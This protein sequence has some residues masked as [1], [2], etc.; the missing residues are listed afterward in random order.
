MRSWPLGPSHDPAESGEP[1]LFR[2]RPGASRSLS[3]GGR[4]RQWEGRG[5]GGGDVHDGGSNRISCGIGARTSRP[6][7]RRTSRTS[8][9]RTPA[10]CRCSSFLACVARN[11]L[12][13]R[14][15]LSSTPKVQARS[16]ARQ[17]SEPALWAA[18][19]RWWRRAGA[20]WS[21]SKRAGSHP[22]Q[23]HS[24][25]C[26]ERPASGRCPRLAR[27]FPVM[28]DPLQGQQKPGWSPPPRNFVFWFDRLF[29]PAIFEG[30][31]TH[32][33]PQ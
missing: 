1:F 6:R 28:S 15:F 13:F 17:H 9:P 14:G 25:R 27:A 16:V 23:A 11:L 3:R 20:L 30:F 29:F 7:T 18:E 8:C 5:G 12:G 32:C 10:R 21:D 22:P 4:R 26:R 33:A 31:H 19:G 2:K 24:P